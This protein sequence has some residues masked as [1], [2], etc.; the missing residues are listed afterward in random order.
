M[1]LKY[2]LAATF[3]LLCCTLSVSA[4][5]YQVS[6]TGIFTPQHKKVLLLKEPTG[7][8]SVILFQTKLRVNTD[9]SPLSYHPQDPRGKDKALNNI[10]NAIVVKKGAS[11]K[12]LCFTSFSEAI[13]V[14]EKFRDSNYQTIPQGFRITWENVLPTIREGG[15]NIPCVFKT[16]EYKGYFGSLTALKNDLTGD[17]GECEI[18]NQVNP[19]TVPA[20]VL[21]GGDSVVRRF[22]AKVGDLLVAYNPKTNLVSSAIIGDTGPRDNLGEGSVLLNMKLLGATTPPTNKTETFKLSIE[23]TQILVAIIPASRLFHIQGNKPY[24]TDNINQR[25]GDWQ[26][27]AG[28][29]APD[30]FID[31]MKSFQ[32]KLN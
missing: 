22:G 26:A 8:K 10:C 7:Q 9:G 21:V 16:G 14:F 31:F 4:Q 1:N 30:K 23:D 17:K 24:T 32:T 5:S 11:D 13:G 3:A 6:Q 25:V 27:N 28:F 29:A 20:L 2:F 18:D 15:K 19:L 12:N